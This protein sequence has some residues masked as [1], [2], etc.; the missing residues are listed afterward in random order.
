M[1]I[2]FIAFTF[3][4][5]NSLQKNNEPG[6]CIFI[7]HPLRRTLVRHSLERQCTSVV[8]GVFISTPV[9]Y[10]NGQRPKTDY[11]GRKYFPCM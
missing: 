11:D 5:A 1:K 2:L 8:A 4:A 7:W 3:Q 9:Y 10:I 6:D